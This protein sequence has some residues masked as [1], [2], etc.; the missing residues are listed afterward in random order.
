M[1]F[2]SIDI[3]PCYESGIGD[4]VQDFYEPVLSEAVLYDRISGFFT[5]TS[6]AV[7]AR[8]MSKFLQNGGIMRLITSPILSQEDVSIIE[9]VMDNSETATAHDFGLD[10]N[11]IEDTLISDHVKAFGWLLA[12]GKIDIKLAILVDNQ[13]KPIT[14]ENIL[15]AGLFHQKVGLLTDNEG[16]HISFSG[17]INETAS[18]WTHNDEEFKVFKD[19]EGS[20]SY[21]E[22][23]KERFNNLWVGNKDGVRT[24]GLPDAVRNELIEFAKDFDIESISAKNY[25]ARKRSKQSPFELEGISLFFYQKE[26][27]EK[28]K[29]SGFRMLFEMATGSGKTRTAIAGMNYIMHQYERTISIIAC[30]QNALAKQWKENEVAQFNL[31]VDSEKVIDGTNAK[32]KKELKTLCLENAAGFAN[33][34]IVYTT[35]KTASSDSFIEILKTDV[36]S[37]TKLIFIGDEVHWLGAKNLKKALLSEYEFRIGLSATPSRWFD[38]EGTT[39]LSNYF[40]NN[41]FEFTISDALRAINPITGKHFLVDYFYHIYRISLSESEGSLYAEI[42]EKISKLYR[43]KDNNQ[44]AAERYARLLEK[45]ANI[46]KNAEGK[47]AILSNVLDDL[48]KN[49][50]MDNLII[51]VSPE[52]REPVLRMLSEKGILHHQLTQEEGNAPRIEFNGLSERQYIIKQFKEKKYNALVAIK[53]LDEGIDIPSACRGI[54]MASSTNPREYV[55]RI[56]RIIRQ[57]RNKAFAYLYDICV[58]SAGCLSE[59]LQPID[60]RI[61]RNEQNRLKEIASNAI[62]SIDALSNIFALN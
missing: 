3:K 40:G 21:Y 58:E 35:H 32:W 42:T 41:H 26:A 25:I 29:K 48:I 49:G 59:D 11:N 43:M 55:Q 52:Q 46:I 62:N 17:S 22:R 2:K 36:S 4:I 56:G 24:I 20:K 28:W 37:S 9:K 18:A 39:Y 38:D 6:L 44:D 5:S 45:R 10:L 57:D 12:Q 53:C 34:C 16:N 13:G 15:S 47:Y 61:R 1:S 31:S 14:K 51:F 8:G 60:S 27:L 30:P 54:L 33:H 7:A 23:D 50:E 19:W